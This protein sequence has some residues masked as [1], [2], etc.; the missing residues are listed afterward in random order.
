[1]VNPIIQADGLPLVL[2][3]DGPRI[4]SRIIANELGIQ[5]E[6]Q[7]Q[8]LEAHREHF[9]AL[10]VFRFQTE[11]PLAGSRGGRPVR[12]ALLNEDQAYFAA[13]LSRNTARAVNVKFRLVKAFGEARKQQEAKN[14]QYLP[15]YHL[16]H[17]ATRQMAIHASSNGSSVPEGIF[18]SNVEK[19]INKAFG[20]EAGQRNHLNAAQRNAVSTAYQ[21]VNAAIADT[22]AMGGSHDLAYQEAKRRVNDFVRLFGPMNG[23][24]SA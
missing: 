8:T 9:E 21:L 7:I 12:F 10:G 2:A 24:L 4:D 20:I 18:H 5:H 1:M 16:A 6:N 15:F 22:L 3:K 13:T 11:K 19:M 23:R 17:D 14:G